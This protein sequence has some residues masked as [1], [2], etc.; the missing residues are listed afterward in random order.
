MPDDPPIAG[1]ANIKPEESTNLQTDPA[2]TGENRA[3]ARKDYD[4]DA[5]DSY[6]IRK[7][8][9]DQLKDHACTIF[10]IILALCVALVVAFLALI[11]DYL[12]HIWSSPEK[13]E[14]LLR[15]IFTHTIAGILG[16]V[17]PLL[18]KRKNG[19]S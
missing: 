9:K 13:V 14:A 11:G 7:A 17:L 16:F 2:A 4:R 12:A 1:L 8:L 10:W 18:S 3:F 15:H 19:D 6:N 5:E